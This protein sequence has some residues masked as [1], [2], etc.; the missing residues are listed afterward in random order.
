[1]AQDAELDRLKAEQDR[2]FHR[3][4]EAWQEQ[5]QAW[6]RRQ[7]AREA[8]NEAFARKQEAYEVQQAA[9]E[10]LQRVRSFNGP[11]IE[12]LNAQQEHAFESMRS[13]FDNASAAHASRDGAAARMYADEGHSYKAEAQAAVAERRQLVQEIRE[14]KDRHEA[15]KPAFQHA[16][17]VFD[18]ARQAHE[19]ARSEHERAQSTF[20]RAKA[21]FGQAKQAFQ[22]RLT[23]VRQAH[24]RRRDDRRSIAERAGVPYA[25]LD[26]VWISTDPDGTTNIYFGGAGKPDGPG[27]GH[28]ALDASGQVLYQRDPNVPH[29]ARNFTDFEQGTL[30]DRSLSSAEPRGARGGYDFKQGKGHATQYYKDNTR[31]SWDLDEHGRRHSIHWTDQNAKKRESERHYLPPHARR[32]QPG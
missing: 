27:H 2:A 11:R 17:A 26:D 4:Q 16:K 14:A 9:W 23:T 22:D 21:E 32:G 15:T 7:A 30:Y 18:R 10:D 13:A 12:S 28:Y 5:D 24:Q 25:Y 29:G 6:Q 20:Q 31:V 8:M 19:A 3:K 1:M